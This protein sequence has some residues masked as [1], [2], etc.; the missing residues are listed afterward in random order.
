[1]RGV[2]YEALQADSPETLGFPGSCHSQPKVSELMK[3]I[4]G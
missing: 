3:M 4:N 2:G 1:V